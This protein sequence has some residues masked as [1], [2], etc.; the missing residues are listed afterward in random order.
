MEQVSQAERW[1]NEYCGQSFTGTI[2][3]GVTFATLHIAKYHMDIQMVQNGHLEEMPTKLYEIL[4]LCKEPLEK[5]KV[6]IKIAYDRSSS[7]FDL[8]NLRG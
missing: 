7:D 1:V 5:N 2:P 8:R 4:K 3:D 6:S